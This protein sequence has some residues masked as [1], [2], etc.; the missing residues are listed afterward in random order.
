MFQYYRLCTHEILC[1][2]QQPLLSALCMNCLHEGEKQSCL[3][4]LDV[5]DVKVGM[6]RGNAAP[7][8]ALLQIPLLI[9]LQLRP[10]SLISIRIQFIFRQAVRLDNFNR[11]Q[12]IFITV[13]YLL[14]IRA[15]GEFFIL[16]HTLSFSKHLYYGLR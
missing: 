8:Q 6:C 16:T 1:C 5:D 2:C 15:I 11:V 9:E 13:V 7:S 4:L 3:K 12:T 10:I 14:E